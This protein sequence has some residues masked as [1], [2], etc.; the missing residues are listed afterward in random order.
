MSTQSDTDSFEER[1]A[2]DGETVEDSRPTPARHLPCNTDHDEPHDP[3]AQNAAT[4]YSDRGIQSFDVCLGYALFSDPRLTT[5][6]FKWVPKEGVRLDD[7]AVGI[8]LQVCTKKERYQPWWCE[9]RADGDIRAERLP[10]GLPFVMN[11][12][13]GDK[14]V[15]GKECTSPGRYY[16]WWKGIHPLMGRAGLYAGRWAQRS[17]LEKQK[18][19][20]MGWK[21][22]HK[23]VE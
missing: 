4:S 11:V 3:Q 1:L 9:F 13:V 8:A 5:L 14:D 7:L 21:V 12:K 2:T 18:C 23:V 10:L 15:D 19:Y 17:S 20:G 16:G 22:G 6:S